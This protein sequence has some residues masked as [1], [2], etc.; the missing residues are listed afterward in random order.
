MADVTDMG[1]RKKYK[2]LVSPSPRP[3][4]TRVTVTASIC[5]LNLYF[6]CFSSYFHT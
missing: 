2:Y 1:K 3:R 4:V 5:K 6:R